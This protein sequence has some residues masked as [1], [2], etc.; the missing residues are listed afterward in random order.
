MNANQEIEAKYLDIDK[1]DVE[2]KLAA[3]GATKVGDLFLRH[4]SFDYPDY[5][6][7]KEYSWIRVRDEGDK[8][9]VAFKK[10]LG[11]TSNDG[12]TPDEGM[13]ELE[14]SVGSYQLAKGFLKK[15]G[16]IEK[17]G[18]A[19]KKRSK[20]RLGTL[21]FDIDTIALIP[22]YLE[23][24]GENWED[25][26]KAAQEL[27]L[28]LSKKKVCSANQLYRSYGIDVTEYKTINFDEVIK[29]K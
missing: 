19:Q 27:G 16:L 4:V 13:E 11:V 21:T 1:D 2:R 20:W 5:R 23:I 10:R 25:V 17:H 3:L 14:F 12:S 6:L 28:D 26:D 15:I 29:K 7:N 24:E 18:E 9:M 22:T 8:V